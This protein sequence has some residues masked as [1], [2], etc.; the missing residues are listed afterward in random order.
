[1]SFKHFSISIKA[2]FGYI[3][4]LAITFLDSV[5]RYQLVSDPISS[6]CN[7]NLNKCPLHGGGGGEGFEVG[8]K[9]GADG[10]MDGVSVG[11]RVGSGDGLGVG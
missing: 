2:F 3:D 4:P 11:L 9:V 1:L 10:F 6:V 5:C 7:L 8:L